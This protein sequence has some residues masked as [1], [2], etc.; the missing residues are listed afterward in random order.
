MDEYIKRSD[1]LS[2]K[3]RLHN[4][5]K[6]TVELY[7][8]YV[9]SPDAVEK[10]PSADVVEVVRCKDCI[11]WQKPQVKLKDGTYRDYTE[12]ET[13]AGEIVDGSV[14]INVGSFCAKYNLYHINRIPQFMGENDFC[15]KAVRMDGET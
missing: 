6:D 3:H 4:H 8:V 2:L 15:S 13:K 14:G 1:V 10:I 9:I 12:E 5:S 11:Y 7:P